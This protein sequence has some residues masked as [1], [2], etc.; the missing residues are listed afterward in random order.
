MAVPVV[1]D[2]ENGRKVHIIKDEKSFSEACRLLREL[3]QNARYKN[4]VIFVLLANPTRDLI[5]EQEE[6]EDHFFE[7]AEFTTY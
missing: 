4:K 3:V 5:H 2:V 7:R 6:G 1:I